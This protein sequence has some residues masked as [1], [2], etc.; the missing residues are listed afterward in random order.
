MFSV[1]NIELEDYY[2]QTDF[3]KNSYLNFINTIKN[4]SIYNFETEVTSQNPILTL[5]TCDNNNKY[6]VV[7]HAVRLEEMIL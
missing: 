5:S 3:D 2:I 1:Y 7:L 4:R 6:R